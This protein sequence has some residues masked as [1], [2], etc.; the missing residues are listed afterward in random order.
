MTL[1]CGT[2]GTTLTYDPTSAQE[3]QESSYAIVKRTLKNPD[4]QT[5]AALET[6]KLYTASVSVAISLPSIVG[7]SSSL[8]EV[9]GFTSDVTQLATGGGGVSTGNS[10]ADNAI[11]FIQTSLD[12]MTLYKATYAMKNFG[13]L[14]EKT[15]S[16]VPPGFITGVAG[17]TGDVPELIVNLPIE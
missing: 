14:P 13:S 7:G 9:L 4:P 12:F 2:N 15:V 3:K 16:A 17:V 8:V 5:K 10:E 1:G 6:I 11:E